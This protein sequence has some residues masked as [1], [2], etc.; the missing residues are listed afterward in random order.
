MVCDLDG[1]ILEMNP[2]AAQNYRKDGG[3]ELVGRSVIECHPEPARS[4]LKQLL[5]TGGSNVYTSEKKGIK[6]LVYQAPWY[7]EGRRQ[8]MVELVLEI[9]LDLPHFVRE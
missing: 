4:K 2:K 3:M 7:Q 9:P 5:E 6:R 8:G 1:I